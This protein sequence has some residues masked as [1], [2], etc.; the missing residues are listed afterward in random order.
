MI[1]SQN[2]IYAV[3]WTI[4]LSTRIKIPIYLI[5]LPPWSLTSTDICRCTLGDITKLEQDK[6]VLFAESFSV[7]KVA[8][9]DRDD[10]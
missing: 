6:G 3:E 5:I 10:D 4:S 7:G 8:T 9:L 1:L 2:V